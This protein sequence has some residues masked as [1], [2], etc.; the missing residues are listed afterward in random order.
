MNEMSFNDAVKNDKTEPYAVD[1]GRIKL[2]LAKNAGFCFGVRRAVELA[3]KTVQKCHEQNTNA[4]VYTYGELI[5]N[6]TVVENLRREGIV[7]IETL[8]SVKAGDSIVIRSHGVPESVFAFLDERNV[9][10][11]DATCPFVRSIHKIANKA[12]ANGEQV[13]IVGD[14]NHPEVI[15]INGHCNN[16]ALF[17]ENEDDLS[18]LDGRSGCLVVQTTFDSTLFDRMQTTISR[19]YPK[20]KIHNTICNVTLARQREA[21]ELSK[22]CDIMLVLGDRHSSN[23]RK[24]CEICK[25]NCEST[26]IISQKCEISIDLS[27][28]PVIIIG[29]VA[30]AST[31]DSIIL[32]VIQTMSEQDKAN[33]NCTEAENKET[34]AAAEATAKTTIDDNAVFDEDVITKTLVRIKPGQILT[35]TVIQIADGEVSVN[36]GYKSDGYIPRNEFSNDPDVDPAQTCKP[37]DE[38]E[39][40]VLKVNDGEGNVLLSRKNVESQKA[41]EEFSADAES[42][43]KILDGVCKEAVKGGL[44]VVLSNNAR[45]FVPASQVAFKFV[46]DLNEYV[47]KPM[48]IKI[49]EIDPKRRRIVGSHKAVLRKEAEE[50]RKAI[51]SKLEVGARIKGTVRRLTDFGAFVDIGG[52]DG[53]VH[54]TQC[55]WNRSIKHPSE[56]FTVGQEVDVIIREIDT[57]N[58]KVSLGYKEL[59]PK[60]WE[61]AAE[62]YPVGSIVEGKV[63]RIVDFGAF[64]SL[65]P[66]IDGLIHVS[67]ISLKRLAK[68]EEEVNIGDT[69]RCKVLSIDTAKR[70]ISLSRREAIMEEQPEVAQAILAEEKAARDKIRAERQEKRQQDEAAREERRRQREE[71]KAEQREQREQRPA[72]RRREEPD[73]ELPPVESATTSL[74]SLLG[75]LHFDDE[76]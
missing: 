40:E 59:L 66:T 57:A 37:G 38:I 68:I 3:R 51:W 54:I 55:A 49:L 8:D 10:I 17:I 26:K 9:N 32:E 18:L 28:K 20:I 23:T 47:G 53:L 5:H 71:R 61:T 65:E 56:V 30:G 21:A 19:L 74:A 24:L 22:K 75:N 76:N 52:V 62:R 50:A 48:K 67:Q 1:N 41:W 70:R 35:G 45:A 58:R 13:F 16:E 64:V 73:Y 6:K 15:G 14:R 43:G 63:V 34:T 4:V 29:I 31:P 69:V 44:I 11:I 46:A 27:K 7:P 60:P 72:R 12:Y 39:V 33:V 25:K 36:I 2:L 42:E